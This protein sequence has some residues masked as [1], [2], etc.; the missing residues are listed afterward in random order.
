M[1]KNMG[2]LSA[3]S[4]VT[5]TKDKNVYKGTMVESVYVQS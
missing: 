2:T 5:V 4:E 1:L 3:V